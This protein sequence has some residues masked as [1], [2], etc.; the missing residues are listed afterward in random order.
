MVCVEA[1]SVQVV[2]RLAVG[3]CHV[4]VM[5][6]LARIVGVRQLW[7]GLAWSG[8]AVKVLLVK[9]GLVIGWHGL[10]RQSR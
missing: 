6:G 2:F 7:V 3:L 10:L 8:W 4:S 1:S 5:Y 9:V